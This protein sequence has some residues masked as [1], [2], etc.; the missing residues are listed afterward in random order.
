VNKTAFVRLL[1]N[2]LKDSA[3]DLVELCILINKIHIKLGSNNKSAKKKAAIKKKL[4]ALNI[5][6]IISISFHH[7][8]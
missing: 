8:V 1:M 7:F 5:E 3:V 2:V 6:V 4:Q